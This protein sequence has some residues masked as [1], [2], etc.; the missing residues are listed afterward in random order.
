[1]FQTMSYILGLLGPE[2]VLGCLRVQPRFADLSREA[3]RRV[4][5][6]GP[7]PGV[8][9]MPSVEIEGVQK[10]DHTEDVGMIVYHHL[11]IS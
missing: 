10:G 11:N 8:V 6:K 1:M 5:S 7:S 4:V 9:F 2:L 3:P